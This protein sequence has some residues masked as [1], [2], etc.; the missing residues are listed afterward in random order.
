MGF[1]FGAGFPGRFIASTSFSRVVSLESDERIST[2]IFSSFVWI[3]ARDA[4]REDVRLSCIEAFPYTFE[5]CALESLGPLG[6]AIA[7]YWSELETF[8]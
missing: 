6:A 4:S 7:T 3:P 2:D 8:P 1:I 5:G